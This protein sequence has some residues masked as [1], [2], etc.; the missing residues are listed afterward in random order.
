MTGEE[1][2]NKAKKTA[3]YPKDVAVYYL[4]LGLTGEAGE[5]AN[6]AKKIIRDNNFEITEEVK[7]NLKKEMGD[8]LWYIAMLCNELNLSMDEVM[9]YNIEKLASRMERGKIQ[10]DGDER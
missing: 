9:Q 6:K 8:V 7:Q 4:T 2:Q 3:V 1:Y 5:I 10:G